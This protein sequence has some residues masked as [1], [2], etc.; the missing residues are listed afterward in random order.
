MRIVAPLL[1]AFAL[2]VSSAAPAPV[3]AQVGPPPNP[4]I[5]PALLVKMAANALARQP[6]ILEMEHAA[7]PFSGSV[8]V[9]RTQAAL[10]LLG[11]F[12]TA[13]GGLAIIDAAA[14]FANAAGIQALAAV[15][16]VAYVHEDASVASRRLHTGTP[17]PW[18]PGRL[19]SLYPQITQA[20]QVW[21]QGQGAGITVAVLDS[22][23][24]NDADLN[25]RIVA[26]AN[27]AD[28]YPDASK[29]PGGH[30]THIAGIIA[31]NGQ[32]T[33]G[34]YVGMAPAAK[35]ADVRVLTEDGGG[36][37]SSVVRGVEWVLGHRT[38]YNIRVMNLSFGAPPPPSNSYVTDP[39][40]AAIEIAVRRGVVAIVAAGNTGPNSG[41]VESPGIDPL[42]I[43]V[44]ALDDQGT[45]SLADD[46]LAWFSAWGTSAGGG[47]KPDV[48][49]PGRKL[50]SLRVPGSKIDTLYP[51]HVG[52]ASNGTSMTRL[53]GTSQATGVVS[54][55]AALVLGHLPELKPSQLKSI[56]TM[57]AVGY[58]G[59]GALPD[60]SADGRGL[61][62]AQAA[63]QSGVPSGGSTGW[64][65]SDAVARALYPALYGQPLVWRDPTYLGIAWNTLNWATLSW[66][67]IAW[68]NIAWDNIAW[69]NIAWD[70]IA[71]DQ[72]AWDN[73]AWDNIAWDNIAWD[74]IAWD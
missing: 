67:N 56:V 39:L 20:Y 60:P 26:S 71:W 7:A 35:I 36:R 57:T 43:T 12:G 10:A 58:G 52:Y 9:Q 68:D 61:L 29:D 6:I 13:V 40:S 14:G 50:Y 17:P 25:G 72:T 18:A 53:T 51:E 37:I 70:N 42:A 49:A 47:A 34:E 63:F 44:G 1:L 31:S 38:Q 8:N 32:S 65:P 74:N 4:K 54:G 16:G 69:D 11:Q 55:A 3:G 24:A 22:G 46:V 41:T 27:F 48:I 2:L 23:V 66:D 15:P 30:G 28:P 73:I 33:A 59:V 45:L 21:A 64:R 5:S 62:N 19:A